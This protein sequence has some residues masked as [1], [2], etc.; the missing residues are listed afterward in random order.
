MAVTDSATTPVSC[1]QNLINQS[2]SVAN[3]LVPST[4]TIP[5]TPASIGLIANSTCE[6]AEELAI[7][8]TPLLMEKFRFKEDAEK[9]LLCQAQLLFE[10]SGV[11]NDS[12]YAYMATQT[13]PLGKTVEEPLILIT[14]P[15]TALLS[16]IAAY[17]GLALDENFHLE[18]GVT[19]KSLYNWAK[20]M[21]HLS[22]N[23]AGSTSASAS[24]DDHRVPKKTSK[25]WPMHLN[26]A[27][28]DNHVPKIEQSIRTVRECVRCLFHCLL[29]KAIPKILS[30]AMV[31]NTIKGLNDFLAQNGLP[32]AQRQL[33]QGNW[34]LTII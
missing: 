25:V 27:N 5:A 16:V 2:N 26:I 24:V 1:C 20:A 3:L 11:T 14:Q 19:Y 7:L 23:D 18:E 6:T 10:K 31:E 15:V 28:T 17:V 32:S 21:L 22:N 29:F 13:W 33:L 9:E 34:H 4:A 30:R 8:V 12:L